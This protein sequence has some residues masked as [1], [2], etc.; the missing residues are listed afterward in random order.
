M[1][2]KEAAA[3]IELAEFVA[4]L[5]AELRAAQAV[6]D[7][8]LRFAVGPVSVEFSVA[9]VREGGPEAKL[10]FWVVEAGGSARWSR[11]AVQKVTLTLTPVDE[12]GAPVHIRDQVAA[13]PA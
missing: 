7:P 6:R 13:P 3:P 2:E 5:R 12:H 10:R 11:E 4:G 1:T 9:T 8:G